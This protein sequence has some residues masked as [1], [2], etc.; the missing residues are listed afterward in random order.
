LVTGSLE[1]EGVL[2]PDPLLT[3]SRIVY[4]VGLIPFDPQAANL[5]FSLVSSRYERASLIVTSNKPF[6]AWARSS[7]TKSSLLP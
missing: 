7:A 4:E 2:R 5:M 1:V 3:T 6:F